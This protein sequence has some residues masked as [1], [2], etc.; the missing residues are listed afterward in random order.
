MLAQTYQPLE[1]ICVENGSEDGSAAFVKENYPQVRLIESKTNLGFCGG[2]NFGISHAKGDFFVLV[3]NDAVMDSD[4][5]EQMMRTVRGRPEVGAVA[6]KIL[7]QD[8][9][10]HLDAAGIAVCMDGLSIG[11][12]RME[13][14]RHY[15]EEAEVFFVSDCV[16]LYR[17]EMIE[18]IGGYDE[19]FFAYAEETDMGWR[20]RLKGWKTIY[21]P[22]AVAYHAHSA[23]LGSY[24]PF[25]IFLVE[26]NRIWVAVKNFPLRFL[27]LG[28]GYNIMRYFYHAV[29]AITRKG[30]AGIFSEKTSKRKLIGVLIK[31]NFSALAGLPQ[32]L[33]Q[34]KG[35][36][37]SRRISDEEVH[38][39]FKRYGLSAKNIAFR[40]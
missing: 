13:E 21:N 31:A 28:I 32:M 17:R 33:A 19:R 35:I 36:L 15:N 6:T 18:D 39:L 22:R 24:H 38:D 26:R 7:L 11:R 16:C 9:P 10:S 3:N 14:A 37:A 4:C 8:Q 12:G 1:L 40:V 34:R 25:K 23:S 5:I 29:G 27:L 2:N 20:A 30:A